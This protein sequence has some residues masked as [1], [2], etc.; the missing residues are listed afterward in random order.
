[1]ELY[2]G[3]QPFM[4]TQFMASILRCQSHR[5][6]DEDITRSQGD[7]IFYEHGRIL[8][9][10]WEQ[11]SDDVTVLIRHPVRIKVKESIE[12]CE[13][14]TCKSSIE[15]IENTWMVVV[16]KSEM[17]EGF[18]DGAYECS[19]RVKTKYGFWKANHTNYSYVNSLVNVP[20][21][22]TLVIGERKGELEVKKL[23][24][25]HWAKVWWREFWDVFSD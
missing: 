20:C 23:P 6:F 18:Q 13:F 12:Q 9:K 22:L 4:I 19:Y 15:F 5:F 10:M 11:Q 3:D 8:R 1:M 21:S 16:A 7:E 25:P 2:K 14:L 17:P 24:P